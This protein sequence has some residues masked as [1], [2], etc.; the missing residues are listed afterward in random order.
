M[1]KRQLKWQIATMQT[2]LRVARK[3]IELVLVCMEKLKQK[4]VAS[5]E[6]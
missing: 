1:S 5:T 3:N 2:K 6:L 4:D